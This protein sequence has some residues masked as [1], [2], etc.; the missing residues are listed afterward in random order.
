MDELCYWLGL[1]L[2]WAHQVMHNGMGVARVLDITRFRPLKHGLL[3]ANH[4]WATG[5]NPATGKHIWPENVVFRTRRGPECESLHSDEVVLEATGRFLACRVAQSCG[6]TEIP[7]GVR[8]RMPHGINYIHGSCHYNSGILL[9]TDFKEAWRHFTCGRFRDEVRR[10]VRLE[11]REVL[12]LFRK[13]EYEPKEFAY[14]ACSLRTLFPWFCNANGPKG[15]VLWGNAAPFPAANLITGRWADDVYA[16]KKPGGAAKVARPAISP[17]Y[18]QGAP[19]HGARD[20][21]IWPEKLLAWITSWR[22]RS[23]GERGGMF[24]VDRREAYSDQFARGTQGEALAKW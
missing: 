2:R 1:P 8:R 22:V 17:R 13:R 5:V 11:R 14:F 20:G 9:F 19:Y 6:E 16:L 18:F 24:F 7:Q 3:P 10:F 15:K 23:R 12:I 21:A 4:P